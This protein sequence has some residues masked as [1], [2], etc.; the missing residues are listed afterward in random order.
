MHWRTGHRTAGMTLVEVVI[1]TIVV[2]LLFVAA[3][4]AVSSSKLTQVRTTD[5]ARAHQLAMDLLAEVLTCAYQDPDG[6]ALFGP[7]SDED[8][9]SRGAFDDLDDYHNWTASPPQD[10]GGTALTEF[11]GF[12]RTVEVQWVQ[13]ED[14]SQT[15]RTATGVKRITVSVARADYPLASVVAYRSAAWTTAIPDPGGVTDNRAPVASAKASDSYTS[16]YSNV[17]FSASQSTDPDSDELTYAWN[18]GD[19][20]TATGAWTSHA[21]SSTGTFTVTLTVSDS[22]GGIDTASLTV[23]VWL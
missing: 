8:I 16:R 7:E 12:S 17:Y 23:K 2:A 1:S 10:K 21:Y 3:L 4:R 13:P 19:G 6:L 18:F 11:E 20:S 15:S 14:L 5:R 22:R 9:T